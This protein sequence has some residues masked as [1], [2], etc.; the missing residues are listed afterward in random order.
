MLNL[1]SFLVSGCWHNWKI[2]ETIPVYQRG[3]DTR[4]INID[5]HLQCEKCGNVKAKRV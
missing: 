2:I 1:I 3:F 5:Y 4:P